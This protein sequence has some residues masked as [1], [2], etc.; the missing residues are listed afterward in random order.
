MPFSIHSYNKKTPQK[1]AAVGQG[2]SQEEPSF[3]A[4]EPRKSEVSSGYTQ[5]FVV[6]CAHA[7]WVVHSTKRLVTLMLLKLFLSYSLNVF[8]NREQCSW[9]AI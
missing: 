5:E 1:R 2:V 7:L 3:S 4:S 9:H 6:D 8:Q